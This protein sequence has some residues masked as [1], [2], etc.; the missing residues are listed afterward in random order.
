METQLDNTIEQFKG[1][2]ERESSNLDSIESTQEQSLNEEKMLQKQIDGMLSELSDLYYLSAKGN[3]RVSDLSDKLSSTNSTIKNLNKKLKIIPS[4][5]KSNARDSFRKSGGGSKYR[6]RIK[7]SKRKKRKSK[8]LKGG[9]NK[10]SF[11]KTKRK[12]R[13]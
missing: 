4:T 2:L 1:A 10:R 13:R 6:L 5:T 3:N 8:R 7:K 9:S 12:T 11:K